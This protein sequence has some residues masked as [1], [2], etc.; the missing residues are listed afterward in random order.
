MSTTFGSC[1]L[2]TLLAAA[3]LAAPAPRFEGRHYAGSGDTEYLELLDTSAQ[4][5][6]P[7]P[8]LQNL[9]MLYSPAW[10][11]FVEG[12]TWG[13]W[14]I[15][16]S[17]GPT[18]CGLPF[19]FEPYSSYVANAQ[20]LWFSQ[21]GDGQRVG[22]G[23]HKWVAPDG[24][25]CD[26]AAPGW[27]FYKQGDGRVD[28]HDWGL[29]FTAAGLV[30]QAEL[31]LVS[32]HRAAIERYLPL[33]ERC[34]N[35]L[36][37][38]RDPRNNLF[39]AGP[40]GNL[41][42]PSYAGWRKPDGTYGQAY[43]AGLS[44]TTI[45]ALDR[46]VELEKLAGRAEQVKLYTQRRDLARQGLPQLTTPEGYFIKYL[47]PDGTRH[48]VY[49]APKHGYF[50]AVC[51]HDAIA[52]RVVDDQQARRIYDQIAAIPGLRRHDVIITNCPSL[53]DL[54]T[55]PKGLWEFG[56]W[57]NGGHWTTCEARMVLAYY[58]L[59]KYED[60]RRSIRH[61]LGFARR[62]RFDNNLVDFGN[63]VYQPKQPLNCV[64]DSWGGPLAML[65]GLFEYLY[66]AEGVTLVPHI[67]PGITRLEQRFPVRLG[68]RRL[69][70]STVGSGPITAVRV[71][72]QPWPL[73]DARTITLPDAKVPAEAQIV[74][75]LGG[76]EPVAPALTKPAA[77][78]APPPGDALW[79]VGSW[80][81]NPLGNG[82][83]L[84]LGA[85]S[86]G[87]SLFV[88]DLRRVRLY[89]QALSAEQVAKLAADPL[90]AAEPAPVADFLLDRFAA[91]A[92]AGAPNGELPAKP[93]GEVA[94]VPE[95]GGQVARLAGK[96]F[97]EVACDARLTLRDSYTLEAYVKPTGQSDRGMRVI[98]RVHAGV[99]DGYLVDL[100]P[101]G[102]VRLITEAGHGHGGG[103]QLG[104]WTHLV[105]T[106]DQQAGL[107]L[108]VNG[109]LAG[110]APVVAQSGDAL[111]ARVG[112]FHDRLRAEGRPDSFEAQQAQLAIEHLLA[113]RERV[114]LQESGR[115][116]PLPEPTHTAA[117]RSYLE[118]ADRLAKGLASLM[119]Q[120]ARG[121]DPARK[122]LAELWQAAGGK[123]P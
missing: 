43:L 8:E 61:L 119:A 113:L 31:L 104:A 19:F 78:V 102:A 67:P 38:R 7:S 49:G 73:H 53:D 41:L 3:A 69:Y 83:P 54:Y 72:G 12:P 22:G 45:A 93:V 20:D 52:F 48:G 39:L 116:V 80:Y 112:A 56:R 110:Q 60:A 66:T 114:R 105:A 122:H 81:R 65:R 28:I 79:N 82:C 103:W 63:A 90:G 46:L 87:G 4:M 84:R 120:Y 107:R 2:L 96:G 15:Q 108:F 77:F 88:G 59:G 40:A 92:C 10:H 106:F 76:A 11:G 17:Y 89:P 34:A 24:C 36:D 18:Y 55:E 33:L 14:W 32:R 21:M 51:N 86:N 70:L 29:E 64:Y 13:A 27:I 35:F 123:A 1:G 58:R 25:L 26:A 99:D 109:R 50:E 111:L 117:N 74:I 118:A 71:N 115:L 44:I 95:G 42:A 100:W 30:L 37:S 85:D 68:D 57:V 94:I 23:E 5:L 16:N 97:L 121:G 75:G 91:G 47:D 98:D 9:G 6:T 101:N 62:F